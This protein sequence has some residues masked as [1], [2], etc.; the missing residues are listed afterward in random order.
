MKATYKKVIEVFEELVNKHKQLNGF[1]DNHPIQASVNDIKYPLMAL[2]PIKSNI[3][4]GGVDIDFKM[5]IIDLMT[6]AYTN[7]RY[8]LD[9]TLQIARDFLVKLYKDEDEYGFTIDEN[10]FYA[11]PFSENIKLGQGENLSNDVGGWV[12]DF[13]V[14]IQWEF[15]ECEL[16]FEN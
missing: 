12:C 6:E 16:P 11:E 7:E 13:T 14:N 15:D 8:L 10:T 5:F 2:Y 1:V 3:K 9:K 4:L